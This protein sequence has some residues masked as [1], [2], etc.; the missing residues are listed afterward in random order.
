MKS[1]DC[2]QLLLLLI[3]LEWL[4]LGSL[5][6]FY[7]YTVTMPHSCFGSQ[8][9]LLVYLVQAFMAQRFSGQ[10]ATSPLMRG[11]I[12]LVTPRYCSC[13][14]YCKQ[15]RCRPC[16]IWPR[17]IFKVILSSAASTLIVGGALGEMVLPLPVGYLIEDNP[18]TFI[19]IYFGYLIAT[20]MTF[21]SM[22]KYASSKGERARA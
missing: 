22:W 20:A 16:M 9:V 15:W 5:W 6:Y 10:S 7:L 3:L 4:L 1:F 11:K 14:N 2:L 18:V 21:L 8:L 12:S 19:Y 17:L 13:W